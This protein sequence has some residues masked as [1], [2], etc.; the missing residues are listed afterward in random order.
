MNVEVGKKYRFRLNPGRGRPAVGTVVRKA[1]VFVVV[2]NRGE[3]FRLHPNKLYAEHVFVPYN[4]KK[5][6]ATA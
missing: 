6:Q 4:T 1:G 5:R 3:E 2:K